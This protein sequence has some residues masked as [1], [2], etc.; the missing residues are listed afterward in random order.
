MLAAEVTMGPTVREVIR[1]RASQRVAL[2]S[3]I[4]RPFSCYENLKRVFD[5]STPTAVEDNKMPAVESERKIAAHPAGNRRAPSSR[6][7]QSPRKSDRKRK[8]SDVPLE[9]P[10]CRDE[11]ESVNATRSA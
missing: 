9:A 6:V 5:E 1:N 10:S 4:L 3:E 7:T 8:Q 11:N 2:S